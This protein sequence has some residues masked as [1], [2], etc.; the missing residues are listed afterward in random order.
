MFK[1]YISTFDEVRKEVK[2]TPNGVRL[3]LNQGIDFNSFESLYAAELAALQQTKSFVSVERMKSELEWWR[4]NRPYFNVYPFIEQ[5]FFELNSEID[6][7]ELTMPYPTIEVRT[8]N[9]TMLLC[10]KK[11]GFLC[12]ID[13]ENGDYQEMV[14]PKTAKLKHVRSG[15]FVKLP[16]NW[17]KKGDTTLSK[18]E[19]EKCVFLAVGTCML[20]KDPQVVMPVILNKHRKESM[21]EAEI[22]IYAE[23]AIARTGRVGFD[24]GREIERMK[25]FVHYRNGCF[26]KYYVAKN[27]KLYPKN[28]EA[29]RVPVIMWRCGAI[30]NKDNVPKVPTGFRGSQVNAEDNQT[31]C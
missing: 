6:M 5:K 11:G 7:A 3:M 27:H 4:C 1:D 18:D 20:A 15:E 2:A 26:A 24:V 17:H 8:Q 23:K 19:L 30:V 31:Y 25:A 29:S 9:R 10:E 13:F 16:D 22:A 12:V 14:F 28:A 21:T